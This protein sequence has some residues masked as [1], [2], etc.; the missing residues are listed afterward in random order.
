MHNFKFLLTR[1]LNTDAIENFFGAIRQQGGNRDNPTPVPFCRAFRKLFFHSFL[2]SSTGNCDCDLDTLLVWFSND[3]SNMPV[4]FNP[5]EQ[6]NTL[7]ICVADYSD[8]NVG[9][10]LIEAN[11]TCYVA[12]L[13]FNEMPKM[14]YMSNVQREIDIQH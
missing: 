12:R 7:D 1:R 11:A 8:N 2:G 14:T 6:P 10:G 9:D 3:K 5:R 4:L 13:P